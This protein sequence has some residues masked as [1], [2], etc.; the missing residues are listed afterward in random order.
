VPARTG[1]DRPVVLRAMGQH[2]LHDEAAIVRTTHSA[3]VLSEEVLER[4]G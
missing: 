1:F 4:R 3:C 2:V